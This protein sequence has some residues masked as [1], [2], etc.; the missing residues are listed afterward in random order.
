IAPALMIARS[1]MTHSG[2]FS[3]TS[4]TRSPRPIPNDLRP[5]ARPRTSCAAAAP[6]QELRAAPQPAHVVRRR[7]PAYRLIVSGTLGPKK[8][9][10]AEPLRLFEEHRRQA[11][12]AVVV[13]SSPRPPGRLST[14]FRQLGKYAW[15]ASPTNSQSL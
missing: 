5:S 11:A 8:R 7:G 12:A 4:P 14:G 3:L 1:A 15:D 10:V 9:F 6:P 2:R 13:H